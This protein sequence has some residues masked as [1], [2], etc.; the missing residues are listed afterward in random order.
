M[1]LRK[2]KKNQGT[3]SYGRDKRPEIEKLKREGLTITETREKTE[4]KKNRKAVRMYVKSVR[5]ILENNISK[6]SGITV[7]AVKTNC[8]W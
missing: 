4:T 6:R 3:D 5:R 8:S 2:I 1:E 7:I